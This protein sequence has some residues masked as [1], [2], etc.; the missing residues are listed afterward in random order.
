MTVDQVAPVELPDF[1]A[2]PSMSEHF[3]KWVG[4][5]RAE[6]ERERSIG[7]LPHP[8]VAR[9][10][11]SGN[12]LCLPPHERL[13]RRRAERALGDRGELTMLDGHTPAGRR[14]DQAATSSGRG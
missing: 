3:R 11:A 4:R 5:R 13:R 8:R 9:M 6:L 12:V 7:E 10:L 2:K 1:D 14:E